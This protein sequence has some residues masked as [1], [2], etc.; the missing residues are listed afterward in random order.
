MSIYRIAKT[1]L[2]ISLTT[3][4]GA[5]CCNKGNI[6]SIQ[7]TR[8]VPADQATVFVKQQIFID[9]T[10]LPMVFTGTGFGIYHKLN[11]TYVL[12]AGHICTGLTKHPLSNEEPPEHTSVF[13][14][15]DRSGNEYSAQVHA[16]SDQ[17]DIC[18]L[19]TDN[20]I[21]VTRLA[22]NNPEPG[23]RIHYSGYPTGM[24]IPNGMN[25]FDGRFSGRS[26]NGDHLYTIPVTSGASG[27][28]VFNEDG[29]VVGLISAVLVEFHHLSIAVGR[30]NILEFIISTKE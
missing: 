2:L 29:E 5:A 19:K 16:I 8:A 24:Y 21:R 1:I 23:D 20:R 26:N 30:E 27:S 4:I 3:F 28:P 14:L 22:K 6:P 17:Y 13:T 25:Y 18:L 9:G 10:P 15:V 12:T 7:Y 11:Y